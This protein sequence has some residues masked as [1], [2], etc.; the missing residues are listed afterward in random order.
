MNAHQKTL[1]IVISN[2]EPIELTDLSNQLKAI[3]EE[4]YSYISKDSF[5]TENNTKIYVKQITKGSIDIE[6]IE[7]GC[8]LVMLSN[9]N[10]ICDFISNFSLLLT[11]LSNKINPGLK[12]K[13]LERVKSIM[14]PII[15]DNE[16][17]ITFGIGNTYDNSFK[18]IL[19][20]NNPQAVN[21][22]NY[23]DKNITEL[24]TP[25]SE[26]NYHSRV[27]LYFDQ[28][29]RYD[30][31]KSNKGII[32]AIYSKPLNIAF[33]DDDLKHK[34]LL[35]EDNPLTKS[36]LVDVDVLMINNKPSVYKIMNLHDVFERD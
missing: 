18:N 29:S 19:T 14:Q 16:G 22:F 20:I 4:Y 1:R 13:E 7:Y 11:K 2:T 8:A 3:A 23:A 32:D 5:A 33:K 27:L 15:K 35:S 26:T 30:N 24:E 36:Y 28:T 10:T 34:V 21:I 12:R 6:L 17:N 9:F 31:K 25:E